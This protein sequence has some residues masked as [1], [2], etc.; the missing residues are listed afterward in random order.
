M[1]ANDHLPPHFHALYREYEAL[2]GIDQVTVLHG[3]L[4]ARASRLVTEWAALHQTELQESWN[5]SRNLQPPI[6]IALL[7]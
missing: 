2:V 1:Y 6:R 4:P 5:K 7:E 3:Y